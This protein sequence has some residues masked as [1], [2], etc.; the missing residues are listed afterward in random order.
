MTT[1]LPLRHVP[2]ASPRLFSLAWPLFLEMLLGMGVGV[3]C[4]ALAARINDT[5]G[6]AFALAL[7]VTG[8]LF[9]LFR[10]V[11]AGVGVV[12][13]Q[14]LGGGRPERAQAV[15]RAVLGAST[16]IGGGTALVALLGAGP[17]LRLMN[18]PPEVAPLAQ[19]LLMALAPALLLDAWNA[20]MASVMRANLRSRDTLFVMVLMHSLHLLL[21]PLLMFGLGSWQGLGLPGFALAV[22]AARSLAL[23]L[24]LY[25]WRVRL[26]L[27]PHASDWWRLPR[28]ELAAVAHIGLP[29]AA[30]NI[31]YR[32]AF[33]VSVA[34]AAS[35]GATA[36]AT[37]AY[38]MQIIFLVLLFGVST[39]FAAEIV[40][41]H[42]IGA[43]K[44]QAAHQLVRRALARGLVVS[45]V[46]A[47]CAALP[48]PWLLR[49]FTQ[50]EAIIRGGT[51]L[52]WLTV[53]L[54]PGRTFNLIVINALRA[55]GDAKYPVRV[56][57]LSMLIVLAGGSWLLGSRLG[58]G[59]PGL[60]IAYAA[61]EWLRGLLMWRRWARLRWVPYA[62]ASRRRLMAVG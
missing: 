29:G 39:G 38:A 58:L 25:F 26:H 61:D 34:V 16:W 30:E 6:A 19:P 24:H 27:V 1:T 59:L 36:L 10:V 3:V 40:V 43:G 14:N 48:G 15:A 31:A 28:Q 32:L 54:E 17:L 62:K 51:V 9:I 60:W 46:V 42:M 33:M 5:A 4:T 53:L 7:N 56:G 37:H 41:G 50:D 23:A 35:L 20:S 44:L 11:G 22:I 2:T 57:A 21:A 45:V 52:L 13:T 12:I 18:A 8:T 55:A 49:L 47:L